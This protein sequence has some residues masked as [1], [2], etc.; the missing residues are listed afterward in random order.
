[1]GT[2]IERKFLVKHLPDAI[3][4][5]PQSVIRQGYLI[6]TEDG[7]ELRVRQKAERFLQT[8]KMG[9]GLSRTEIEIS[10]S[11]DQFND[12]WPHTAGRRVSKIRYKVP[13]GDHTAELDCFD[14][15]LA[16]LEMV[17]VEFSSIEAS[18]QFAPP[19]WFGAE[20]TE[21]ERYKNKWLAKNGKPGE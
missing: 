11:G 17:E 19:A 4:N 7:M 5:Y 6:T 15:D 13:V 10:L 9:K 8:I 3:D 16:G 1:M 20:V 21:D 14:G 2:E 18:Q 12:L